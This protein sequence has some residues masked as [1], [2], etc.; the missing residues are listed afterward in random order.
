MPCTGTGW[1][2]T[3]RIQFCGQRL[4]AIC[5]QTSYW[6]GIRHSS[7]ET[8][9]VEPYEGW[10]GQAQ[11]DGKVWGTLPAQQSPVSQTPSLLLL[12]GSWRN[13][14]RRAI[15]QRRAAVPSTLQLLHG[16]LRRGQQNLDAHSVAS[17]HPNDRLVPDNL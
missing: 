11:V 15:L 2:G 7:H 10:A 8:A 16:Y 9:R 12:Q 17:L 4:E 13:E 6:A 5:P 14:L 3:S 1:T